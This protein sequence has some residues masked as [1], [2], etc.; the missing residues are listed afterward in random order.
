MN[1]QKSLFG[2]FA[3]FKESQ[4]SGSFFAAEKISS[5]RKLGGCAI[6]TVGFHLGFDDR[7]HD[8][9]DWIHPGFPGFP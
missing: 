6:W 1:F 3:V 2:I 7:I 8:S 4:Q 9:A 5:Q